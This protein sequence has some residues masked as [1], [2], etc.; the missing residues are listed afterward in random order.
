M[1]S[2][3]KIER[4][5]VSELSSFPQTSNQPSAYQKF[6]Q[7][8]Q[9]LPSGRLQYNMKNQFIHNPQLLSRA[10][11]RNEQQPYNKMLKNMSKQGFEAKDSVSNEAKQTSL[12][13]QPSF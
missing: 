1:S 2:N 8:L 12:S 10:E 9:S 7:N 6:S 4:D 11:Q 3:L 13:Q 5:Q